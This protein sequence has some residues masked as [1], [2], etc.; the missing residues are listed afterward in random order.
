MELRAAPRH[1]GRAELRASPWWVPTGGAVFLQVPDG[2]DH[3]EA[4]LHAAVGVVLPGLREARHAVV[5]ISQDL[6]P[7]AVILLHKTQ[8][9]THRQ[10]LGESTAGGAS[11][12]KKS[13]ALNPLSH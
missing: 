9:Q 7:Q 3:A 10:S 11:E 8:G 2:F 5:T 12:M 6:D 1:E 13:H 4:H